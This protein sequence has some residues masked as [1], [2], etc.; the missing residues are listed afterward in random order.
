MNDRLGAPKLWARKGESV[1]CINGH[2]ICDIAHDIYSG[3][4]RG[5]SDFTNWHQPE[6]GIS[7]SVAGLRCKVCRGAWIRGNP[8][9]GYQFHFG[10]NPKD[11]WR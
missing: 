9:D 10:T 5:K 7:E 1:T 11:G 2:P 8:R 6:P 3:D 4:A